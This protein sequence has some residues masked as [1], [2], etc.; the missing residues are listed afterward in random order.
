M[1]RAQITDQIVELMGERDALY[2]EAFASTPD[3]PAAI[4]ALEAGCSVQRRIDALRD[5]RLQAAA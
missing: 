1:K 3:D 4:R 5:E 2:G